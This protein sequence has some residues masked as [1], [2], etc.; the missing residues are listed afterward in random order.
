MPFF[1]TQLLTSWR[2]LT[3]P[4]HASMPLQFCWCG[5][6]WLHPSRRYGTHTWRHAYAPPCSDHSLCR[7][8]SRTMASHPCRLSTQVQHVVLSKLQWRNISITDKPM[9]Y[10]HLQW[11]DC[12]KNILTNTVGWNEHESVLNLNVMICALFSIRFSLVMQSFHLSI[13]LVILSYDRVTGQLRS[14]L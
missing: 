8:M 14:N 12:H 9:A 2:I 10:T 11:I 4:L 13:D 3:L 6:Q 5:P 7:L 1:R